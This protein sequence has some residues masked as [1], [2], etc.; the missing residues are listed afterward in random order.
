MSNIR[1]VRKLEAIVAASG[2]TSAQHPTEENQSAVDGAQDE[3][4][5]DLLGM[6]MW[7][8]SQQIAQLMLNMPP[9]RV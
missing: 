7:S 5:Y 9:T 3:P 1:K 8:N 4:D 2:S 6:Y